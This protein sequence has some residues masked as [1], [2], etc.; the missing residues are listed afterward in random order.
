MPQWLTTTGLLAML[1]LA[2]AGCGDSPKLPPPLETGDNKH[3]ARLLLSNSNTSHGIVTYRSHDGQGQTT[4]GIVDITFLPRNQIRLLR[5]DAKA[6]GQL[7][8]GTYEIA[9]DGQ[10]T[11]H[12]PNLDSGWPAV[13]IARDDISVYLM[14]ANKDDLK[15]TTWPMRPVSFAEEDW[16]HERMGNHKTGDSP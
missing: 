2:Q 14:P 15:T 10:I 1:C 3:Q 16:L 9:E 6:G 13:K 5:Q 4:D 8:T 12:V 7:F 11:F